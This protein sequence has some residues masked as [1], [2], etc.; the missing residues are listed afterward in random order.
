MLNSNTG[1]KIITYYNHYRNA[2]LSLNLP[3]RQYLTIY[4]KYFVIPTLL[5][6]ILSYCVV[7]FHIPFP[8]RVVLLVLLVFAYGTILVALLIES[9][10]L[11]MR[12]YGL[13]NRS[14]KII[15]LLTAI[16]CIIWALTS[17]LCSLMIPG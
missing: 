2:I 8:L 4:S 11:L 6:L 15:L 1:K 10:D 9:G 5:V 12:F 14:V 17:I 16:G 13:K 3:V 7:R